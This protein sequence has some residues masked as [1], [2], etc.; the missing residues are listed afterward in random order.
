MLGIPR[1]SRVDHDRRFVGRR[2]KGCSVTSKDGID[3]I[4]AFLFGPVRQDA[5]ALQGRVDLDPN[6]SEW[7]AGCFR[8]GSP[9]VSDESRR[10][11][12]VHDHVTFSIE[13]VLGALIRQSIRL[14]PFLQRDALTTVKS[15]LGVDEVET[16]EVRPQ[17]ASELGSER[18][19]AREG[20]AAHES[21]SHALHAT[22]ERSNNDASADSR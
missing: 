1:R 19:L 13:S 11:G 9:P 10:A 6:D 5:F 2:L 4:G 21:Q 20:E 18:A 15:A 8:D 17:L 3:D 16:D 7:C 14:S 12:V 22:N